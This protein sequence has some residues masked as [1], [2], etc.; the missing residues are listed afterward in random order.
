MMLRILLIV[1]LIIAI[2]GCAQ[3]PR[4]SVELSATIGRDIA[5]AH[6]AHAQLASLLF[7]KMKHD[8]N[9]F[10][11]SVYVPY[12]IRSVME[13][14][15]Q[16]A[17]S[18]DPKER[19]KSLLIGINVAFKPGASEELQADVLKGMHEVVMAIHRDVEKKRRELLDPLKKQEK[20]VLGSIN[21][22]YQQIHYAN[23]IVTGHLSSIVKVHEAQSDLLAEFG[24]ERDLRKEIGETLSA[25]SSKITLIVDSAESVDKKMDEIEKSTNS[26]LTTITE[27]DGVA[28]DNREVKTDE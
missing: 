4:E 5:V 3:V 22:S 18:T 13:R 20:S 12:Q 24:V 27:L 25:V 11:D 16:L 21:R 28:I 15:K 8:V 23:S 19:Q 7:D 26:L 1:A 6:K 10:V 14:Q 9:R 17:D 2:T